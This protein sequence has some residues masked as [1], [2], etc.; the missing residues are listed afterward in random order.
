MTDTSS[1]RT[2]ITEEKILG[3]ITRAAWGVVP[4]RPF[5]YGL[6]LSFKMQDL[7]VS[8]GGKYLVNISTVTK[9]HKFTI[10]DQKEELWESTQHLLRTLVDAK[11]NTVAELKGLPVEVTLEGNLFK[12]FRILTEVL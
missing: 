4:D 3:R 7:G 5:L 6:E 10:E 1:F 12:D 8:S 2:P 9:N 11:V